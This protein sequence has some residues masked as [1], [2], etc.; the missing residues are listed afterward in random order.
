MKKIISTIIVICLLFSS[1]STMAHAEGDTSLSA[2]YINTINAKTNESA[3]YQGICKDGTIY[4]SPND[5]AAIG[6][7]DCE[8][9]SL[10][11][12]TAESIIESS[13]VL[14]KLYSK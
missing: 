2:G 7:Y 1:V 3:S 4:M 8:L 12:G 9:L 6:E 5:I 11:R 10:E 14:S 13:T